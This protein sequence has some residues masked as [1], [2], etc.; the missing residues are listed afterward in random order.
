MRPFVEEK[1]PGRLRLE[2]PFTPGERPGW[3]SA[4]EGDAFVLGR[5]RP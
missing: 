2:V 5:T 1:P 3:P 4:L